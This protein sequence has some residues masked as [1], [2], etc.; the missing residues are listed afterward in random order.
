MAFKHGTDIRR[1]SHETIRLP[2]NIV[3]VN[4]MAV[5]LSGD[6]SEETRS[7]YQKLR[8]YGPNDGLTLLADEIFPG[9]VTVLELGFDHFFRDPDINWKTVVLVLAVVKSLAS[10]QVSN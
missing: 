3:M 8:S 5:P 6:I 4:Y 9:S 10:T 2:D 7:R 1:A